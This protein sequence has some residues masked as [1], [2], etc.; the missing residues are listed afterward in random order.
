MIGRYEHSELEFKGAPYDLDSRSSVLE[1]AKDVSGMANAMGGL[2]VIGFRTSRDERRRLD[3]VTA[4]RPIERARFDVDRHERLIRSKIYPVVEGLEL[5][6]YAS[7][8]GGDRGA[9]VIDIPRQPDEHKYFLVIEPLDDEGETSG[10]FVG[11]FIRRSDDVVPER[12]EDLYRLLRDGRNVFSRLDSIDA[13]LERL[14]SD[15]EAAPAVDA[16]ELIRRVNEAL[17]GG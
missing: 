10:A 7:N 8:A 4:A 5:R 1:L 15:G 11:L 17:G 3:V 9:L 2:L 12:P 14:E 16:D 13:R 6:W